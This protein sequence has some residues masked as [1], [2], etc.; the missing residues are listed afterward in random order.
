MSNE[1]G[2]TGL[3][4]TTG[5]TC[6]LNTAIQMLSHT[7]GMIEITENWIH[8]QP[9]LRVVYKEH[10]QLHIIQEWITIYTKIWEQNQIINPSRFVKCIQLLAHLNKNIELT[11][12]AEQH[13]VNEVIVFIIEEMH[14]NLS[15]KEDDSDV[16]T[17]MFFGSRTTQ[18]HKEGKTTNS[19][20]EVFS[21]WT[22]PLHPNETFVENIRRTGGISYIE[23]VKSDINPSLTVTC[24][25]RTAILKLPRIV[26]FCIIRYN[27]GVNSIDLPETIDMREFITFSEDKNIEKDYIYRLYATC[28]HTGNLHS[29]HY[30]AII[31]NNEKWVC[32]NDSTIH[33][34]SDEQARKCIPYCVIY[35]KV[36]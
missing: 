34:I 29:G 27:A 6:F 11:N 20:A 33:N 17:Q 9:K 14:K 22:I 15:E 4:N 10:P 35:Q 8:Q 36:E 3:I 31:R 23:G 2:L 21:L 7:P 24:H 12:M 1:N 16:I 19:K 32:I 28:I 25:T 18:I 5:N 30:V 26:I 13:D